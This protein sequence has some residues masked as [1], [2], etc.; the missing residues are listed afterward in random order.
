MKKL[1]CKLLENYI[2]FLCKIV[3]FG[4]TLSKEINLKEIL[5]KVNLGEFNKFTSNTLNQ[6][7]PKVFV[8]T[9]FLQQFR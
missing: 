2:F 4:K 9:H 8:N 1:F 3:E 5:K 6:I 7:P